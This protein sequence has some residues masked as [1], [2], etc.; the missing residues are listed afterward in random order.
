MI[1]AGRCSLNIRHCS[2]ARHAILCLS[3]IRE[4]ARLP[5]KQTPVLLLLCALVVASV[6][7]IPR[8]QTAD[9]RWRAE[10]EK[11]KAIDNHTHVTGVVVAGVEDNEYEALSFEWL[12]AFP[13]MVRLSAGN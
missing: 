4:E 6:P 1:E 5:M 12:E 8:A 7:Q 10:I 11:I 13:L 9:S 2:K 3:Q